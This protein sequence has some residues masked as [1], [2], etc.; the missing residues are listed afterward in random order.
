MDCGHVVGANLVFARLELSG[1]RVVG[2]NLVFARLMSDDSTIAGLR[3]LFQPNPIKG[4]F[5]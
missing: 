4:S 3:Y 2:A 1:G 5:L